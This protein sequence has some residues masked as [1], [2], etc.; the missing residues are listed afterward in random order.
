MA[1][2]AL[3]A[4]YA[5]NATRRGASEAFEVAW[6][7]LFRLAGGG[8]PHAIA[9]A[10][11]AIAGPPAAR[12]KIHVQALVE[13]AA[14]GWGTPDR[15]AAASAALLARFLGQPQTIVPELARRLEAHYVPQRQG[16]IPKGRF[17]TAQIADWLA[18][19]REVAGLAPWRS[20]RG[21]K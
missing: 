14:N 8:D 1:V 17:T 4:L 3:V 20:S 7:G 18:G 11:A 15:P 5:E 9:R 2:D 6:A 21:R 13:S 16:R 10:H 19:D 12:K